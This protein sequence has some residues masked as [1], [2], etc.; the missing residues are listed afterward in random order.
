M[1]TLRTNCEIH[2]SV[3]RLFL[4][5]IDSLTFFDKNNAV[6][7][8]TDLNAV[9]NCITAIA[10]EVALHSEDA[11]VAEKYTHKRLSLRNAIKYKR[12]ELSKHFQKKRTV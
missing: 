7:Y 6:R 12:R 2:H 4:S 11:V 5:F 3:L 9:I 10:D 1:K 8:F